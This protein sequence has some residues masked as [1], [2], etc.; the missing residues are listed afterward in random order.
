[1]AGA[2]LRREI[3]KANEEGVTR[4]LAEAR[5]PKPDAD[6]IVGERERIIAHL[7]RP[8][9]RAQSDRTFRQAR[10]IVAK[11]PDS[12]AGILRDGPSA[13]VFEGESTSTAVGRSGDGEKQRP[14]DHTG[15]SS[16]TDHPTH[17]RCNT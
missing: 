14:E 4:G 3:R 12:G 2:R 8:G 7:A 6:R 10:R 1:R 15:R 17:R 11:I 9:G 16:P 13:R 5:V